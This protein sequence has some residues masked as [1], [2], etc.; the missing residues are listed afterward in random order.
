MV[1][2]LSIVLILIFILARPEGSD[3]ISPKEWKEG[4]LVMLLLVGVVLL[5]GGIVYYLENFYFR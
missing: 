1:Y 4:L 5:G 3:Q 2:V